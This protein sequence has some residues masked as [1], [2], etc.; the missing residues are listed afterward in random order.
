MAA[1]V[2]QN[3][4]GTNPAQNALVDIG[5][6]SMIASKRYVYWL[7]SLWDHWEL[8]PDPR[9]FNKIIDH[10]TALGKELINKRQALVYPG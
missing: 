4:F 6:N 3:E 5:E 2:R 9:I 7:E 8:N 1:R 10:I